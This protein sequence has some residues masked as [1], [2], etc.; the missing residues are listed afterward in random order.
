MLAIQQ[1]GHGAI[2]VLD[3]DDTPG[4]F[5]SFGQWIYYALL[6]TFD[7]NIPTDVLD[8]PTE[9][10]EWAIGTIFARPFIYFMADQEWPPLL[11]KLFDSARPP[12]TSAVWG[13]QDFGQHGAW[14]TPQPAALALRLWHA[15]AA[16]GDTLGGTNYI[17]N[18][19]VSWGL[20]FPGDPD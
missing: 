20:F 17:V 19:S 8:D 10:G 1:E 9:F 12:L 11:S 16:R 2:N 13:P 18:A 7:V 6:R 3:P 5:D 4:T 15:L 14:L